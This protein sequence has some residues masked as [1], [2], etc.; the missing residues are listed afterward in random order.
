MLTVMGVFPANTFTGICFVDAQISGNLGSG[1]GGRCAPSCK[2][3][4]LRKLPGV[5]CFPM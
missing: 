5:C 3:E 4:E 1:G 2:R